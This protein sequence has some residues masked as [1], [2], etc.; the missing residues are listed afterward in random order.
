MKGQAVSLQR[1]D[2]TLLI[3]SGRIGVL[4]AVAVVALAHTVQ[5]QDMEPRAYSP[6]PLGTNFLAVA[7]GNSRGAVLFDPTVP[8]TDAQ[9]DLNSATVG[10]ARTFALGS[11]QGL[12]AALLPYVRG[13]I[14][15]TVFE[16][17]RRVERSGL[18]DVRVKVS[19]NL[20]GTEAMTR[21]EFAK[22]PRRTIVGA[23]L[24]VQAP[25]GQYDE[26][27]LINIGTNRWSFKPEVGVSV[28]L[29]RWY[30]DAYAGAWFF[31]A[32]DR[33]Y[34]GN[35]TRRQDPLTVLQTHVS[36]VFKSHA[37][38]AIDATWYGGG[39]ATVGSNPPSTRQS[40]SRAGATFALPLTR[41]QSLKFAASTGTSTRTGTDFRTYLVGW[42]LMWFD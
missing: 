8:V 30:L 2:L 9:A 20:V 38:V 33:F 31:T 21:E 19:I 13:D 10:Y 27:K 7:I 3:F 25:T 39:A 6:S 17:S 36:Y 42:Q 26:T 15:G 18:A 23:S 28:P 11:R 37:W 14:A 24:T 35:A 41:S 1:S 16:E 32:N 29:G 12:V 40:N 22:A 34:P 5:A 4:V